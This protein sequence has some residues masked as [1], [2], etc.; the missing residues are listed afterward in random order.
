MPV[1]GPDIDKSA[2]I[3][4]DMQNDFL[5]PDGAFAQRAREQPEKKIDMAFLASVIPNVK[6]LAAAFREAGRPVVYI[7]QVLKPDYS[8]AAF[9]YWK[10]WSERKASFLF[11]GTQGAQIID[12]LTPGKGEHLIVKKGYSGFSNTPLDTLLRNLGVSTCVVTG[13]TT[14]VCVSSTVRGAVERNYRVVLVKDAVAEVS[15]E[16]HE[17]ELETI[18]RVF[19]DVKSA[20]EV[21]KTLASSS[22]LAVA[23]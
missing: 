9:P 2:M 1:M 19:G 7:A 11:E 14:C 4:V 17:A 12:E 6:R 3:I 20:D 23:D 13:V 21:I 18:A 16:A 15:R 5:H 8:D 10:G 22:R